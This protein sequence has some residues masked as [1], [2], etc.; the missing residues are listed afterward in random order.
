ME[1]SPLRSIPIRVHTLQHQQQ[2]QQHNV[3]GISK[4]LHV[5]WVAVFF[6]TVSL[7]WRFHCKQDDTLLSSQ[8]K[9]GHTKRRWWWLWWC[10]QVLCSV[11][12]RSSFVVGSK[13][14]ITT[15]A[16]ATQRRRRQQKNNTFWIR[17]GVKNHTTGHLCLWV[18]HPLE[19][20]LCDL[21]HVKTCK[22]FLNM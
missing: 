3:T 18:Q 7:L 17:K 8:D 19:D 22:Y 20:V 12:S 4:S 13:T 1:A 5:A 9:D 10:G 21:W 2:Q 6:S 11:E 14:G 16:T 15:T